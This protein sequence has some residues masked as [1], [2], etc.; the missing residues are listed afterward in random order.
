MLE[1]H[2]FERR[3]SKKIFP[4]VKLFLP[5]VKRVKHL[6]RVFSSLSSYS[7]IILHIVLRYRI[8][9]SG[10]SSVSRSFSKIPVSVGSVCSLEYSEGRIEKID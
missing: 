9:V 6:K 5:S 10:V 3:R 2:N 8:C 7:K 4:K 1:K